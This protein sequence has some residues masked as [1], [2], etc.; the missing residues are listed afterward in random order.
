M[1]THLVWLVGT[2]ALATCPLASRALE[3]R[4]DLVQLSPWA[5]EN[6]DRSSPEK[7][8]GIYVDIAKEF[9]KRSGIALKTRLTPYAQVEQ[10]LEDG[11]CDLSF[12]VGSSERARF[13]DRGSDLLALEFGVR[14]AKGVTLKSYNDLKAITVSVTQ[15]LKVDPKFDNDASLKKEFDIDYATGV[16]KVA[17]GE[18]RRSR[19]L[20]PQ[21]PRSSRS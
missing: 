18:S 1:K 7:Y 11:V 3:L 16:K 20:S 5:M 9:E 21:C 13:A 17:A 14:A 6:P 4:V 2:I 12:L 15:G 19:E 8:V 10:D